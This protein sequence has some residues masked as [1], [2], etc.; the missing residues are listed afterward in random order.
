MKRELRFGGLSFLRRFPEGVTALRAVDRKEFAVKT[1]TLSV[2]VGVGAPLIATATASAGF[3]G[4]KVVSKGNPYSLLVCNVY[5]VFDRPGED[6]MLAV[7]G[8]AEYPLHIFVE[9]GT[10]YN[11]P[12]GTDSAPNPVLID[13]FPS[14]AYDSFYTIGK[15]T[16]TGDQLTLTVGLPQLVGRSIE[17]TVAGWALVPNAPQGDPFDPANSFPGNGQILIGQ[18]STADGTGIG[19]TFGLQFLS[20]GVTENAIVSFFHIPAPGALT[21]LGAAG[22]IGVRRRR[23]R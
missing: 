15:K 4:I 1:K 16:S 11:S 2:L 6:Q 10:F 12:F 20:N 5:A 21:L 18:F 7:Y 9:G 23:R 14:L 19:G 22:L 3:L 17:T 8:S 13:A